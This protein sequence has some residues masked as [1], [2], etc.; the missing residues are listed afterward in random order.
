MTKTMQPAPHALWPIYAF[1]NYFTNAARPY[2]STERWDLLK[3]AGY[4]AGY[5]GVNRD[6]PA[7]RAT[8]LDAHAQSKRT[9]LSLAAIYCVLDLT[10]PQPEGHHSVAEI[11][12]QLQPGDVLE[13]GLTVG[14][15]KKVSDPGV[16]DTA[17][18]QLTP[19]LA[20]AKTRNVVIA[21]YHHLGF[22]L[23]RIEDCVRL[24]EK[25]NDPALGVVFCGYHWYAVDRTELTAKLRLAAPWL[26]RA[27]LCGSRPS[28]NND[29]AGALPA[30]IECVG[31]GEFP[32]SEF[33]QALKAI[34]YRGPVGF[35]GYKIE[36][37]PEE[38][39]GKS[40]QAFQKAL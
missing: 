22:Y 28:P 27:N 18:A 10:N 32:L 24:A 21:L 19:L 8:L 40:I 29:F 31:E 20:L 35:Q 39:L 7:S 36:G 3:A 25:I 9:G 4:R 23:E 30:T 34:D 5:V 38:N 26:K 11:I 14:W 37:K 1:D 12:E 33:V 15:K 13:L 17:I 6:N 16:D 2:T